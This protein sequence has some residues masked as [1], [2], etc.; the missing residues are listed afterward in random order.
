MVDGAKPLHHSAHC[1]I[2][3]RTVVSRDRIFVAPAGDHSRARP[4]INPQ[5]GSRPR[6]ERQAVAAAVRL[7]NRGS[8]AFCVA[9]TNDLC[10]RCT[11]LADSGPA[12]RKAPRGIVVGQIPVNQVLRKSLGGCLYFLT[13]E[14]SLT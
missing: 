5:E 9:C 10:D 3:S 11:D 14:R 8:V 6:L 4:G 2:W 13:F 1:A 12:Y 7:G